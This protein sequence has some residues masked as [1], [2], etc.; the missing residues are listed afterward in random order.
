MLNAFSINP[1]MQAH[2]NH[3]EGVGRERKRAS[4]VD[5]RVVSRAQAVVVVVVVLRRFC[6][7]TRGRNDKGE[8]GCLGM[9][10]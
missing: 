10:E 5:I 2:M 7:V 3:E 8:I 9:R 4:F 6:R 1:P